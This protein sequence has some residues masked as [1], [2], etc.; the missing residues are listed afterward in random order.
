VNLGRG[1]RRLAGIIVH[2][3]P[4]KLAAVALATLLYAGFV[5]SQDSNTYLGPIEITADNQPPDTVVTNQLR[6]VEEIRYLAAADV[7][8]PGPDDFVA[9][10]DLA[11]VEPDGNPVT[12]PVEVTPI[13]PRISIIGIRPATVSVTL[14]TK[15]S[16]PV[17]VMVDVSDPPVGL[18]LGTITVTPD[19]VAVTGPSALVDRVVSARVTATI[20]GSG[21]NIDRDVQPDA[22]DAN[23]EIVTGVDVEPVTVRLEIPVFENLE[24]RTIPVNPVVTGRPGAGFRIAS[25]TVDPQV[26]TVE[27]DL[28]QLAALVSAD[29]APLAISGATRNVTAEVPFTL[30]TGVTAIGVETARVTVRIEPVTET[31]TFT[32]GVQ[33]DGRDPGFQYVAADTQVLL[34][35][36]GTTAD[37]DRLAASP[38]VIAVDVGGLEPGTHEVPVVP[39]LDSVYT[40]AAVSPESITVTVI[41]RPTPTP[42]PAPTAEATDQ[43]PADPAPT[44]AAPTATP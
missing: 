1:A 29:T 6:D 44:D 26:V 40:V 13:D 20:D 7:P 23:G 10:V 16:K 37:L 18:Q 19:A 28:D 21:V 41:P 38:I 32:A 43:A 5:A 33:L 31:R 39:S 12:V 14:D 17:Q 15:I 4:L 36:F 35:V 9:T 25:V 8:I 24:N 42:E 22:V 3:W 30:P 34:T 27:G 11:D 2:N